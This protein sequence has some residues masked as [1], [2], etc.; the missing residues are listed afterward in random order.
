[1]DYALNTVEGQ[2]KVKAVMEKIGDSLMKSTGLGN[3]LGKGGKK[4]KLED[5]IVQVALGYAQ[6]SGIINLG[7]EGQENPQQQSNLPW[8]RK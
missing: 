8:E 2:M 4:L 5:I 1:M 7:G 6:K 3:I